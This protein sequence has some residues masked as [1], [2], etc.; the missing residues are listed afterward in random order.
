M[1]AFLLFISLGLIAY[2]IG[3]PVLNLFIK[4]SDTLAEDFVFSSGLGLGI[5]GYAVYIIGSFGFLYPRPIII[6]LFL[7]ALLAAPYVYSFI[8]KLDWLS[9]AKAAVSLGLFEK[10]LLAAIIAIS[11][12]CLFGSMAPEIGN[13]AL[14]YHLHH[15]KIFIQNHKIGYIPYTR[16]SLWPYLT[17]M[18]FTVGLLFKSV[19]LAKMFNFLFGVLSMLS[20]YV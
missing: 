7:F 13:D 14:V 11:S 8:R 3:K 9:A 10:F 20:V 12:M 5:L 19:S 16:E 1:S 6:S 15:P 2:G 18:L 4:K 17:E